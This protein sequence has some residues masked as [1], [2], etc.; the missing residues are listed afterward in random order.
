MALIALLR[1]PRGREGSRTPFGITCLAAELSK[2]PPY[3]SCAAPMPC[4]PQ[5]VGTQARQEQGWHT[6]PVLPSSASCSWLLFFLS[7]VTGG[8]REVPGEMEL[9]PELWAG[10]DNLGLLTRTLGGGTGSQVSHRDAWIQAPGPS[11]AALPRCWHWSSQDSNQSSDTGRGPRP[12]LTL[13][14]LPQLRV[15]TARPL[16]SR[17]ACAPSP[18]LAP[19]ASGVFFPL[20][21]K[22]GQEVGLWCPALPL[23]ND[24]SLSF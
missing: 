8:L 3:S 20:A 4:C 24:N 15:M 19:P 2:P 12:Q 21:L 11:C 10:V 18:L 17:W 22:V 13:L 1:H 16:G 9:K 7:R 23:K 6:R 14:F 5:G